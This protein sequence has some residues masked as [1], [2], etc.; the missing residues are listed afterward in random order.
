MQKLNPGESPASHWDHTAQVQKQHFASSDHAHHGA[1]VEVDVVAIVLLAALQDEER[2][3]RRTAEHEHA[4]YPDARQQKVHASILDVREY[5]W[6]TY[7]FDGTGLAARR[8]ATS[9]TTAEACPAAITTPPNLALTA[10]NSRRTRPEHEPRAKV[11]RC[12]HRWSAAVGGFLVELVAECSD[13][14]R[15]RMCPRHW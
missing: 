5:L 3:P 15:G 6:W 4:D 2:H 7:R 14:R 12:H 10:D 9:G 13:G 8:C 11:V 1:R